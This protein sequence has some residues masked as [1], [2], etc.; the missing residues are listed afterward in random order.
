MNSFP[1]SFFIYLS[2]AISYHHSY[3]IIFEF[4][5][6]VTDAVKHIK[7]IFFNFK[8][9]KPVSILIH[10]YASSSTAGRKISPNMQ[11]YLLKLTKNQ[12]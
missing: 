11:F 12:K 9:S 8:L 7:H 2:V 10:N 5:T 1:F 3:D 4:S 6:N